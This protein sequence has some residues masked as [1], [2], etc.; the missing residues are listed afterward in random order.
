MTLKIMSIWLA[1]NIA[2]YL[3]YFYDKSA[4]RSGNWRIS[5]SSLIWLAMLGGSPAAVAA[6]FT[7]R[8]KTR[9]SKFRYGAPTILFL[10]AVVFGFWLYSGAPDLISGLI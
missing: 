1:L 2:T 4:A 3:I 7:L 6:I 8:H 5:E 10:Q 9:K